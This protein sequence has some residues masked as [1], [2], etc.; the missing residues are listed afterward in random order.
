MDDTPPPA[1][2]K[3]YKRPVVVLNTAP[4][5]SL[6]NSSR[7]ETLNASKSVQGRSLRPLPSVPGGETT[8]S[9]SGTVFPPRLHKKSQSAV[10]PS[11]E[12]PWKPPSLDRGPPSSNRWDPAV[13]N[14]SPPQFRHREA[15][16][17]PPPSSRHRYPGP[18]PSSAGNQ[19]PQAPMVDP[20]SFYNPAVSGHLSR[21]S[22]RMQTPTRSTSNNYP[23]NIRP[24]QP[25]NTN[26]GHVR[27]AS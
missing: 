7:T 24:N 8:S 11:I 19:T 17:A 12:R 14:P 15:E 4:A 10:I 6:D 26:P 3:E 22:P 16:F 2:S 25:S 13:I 1:Y 20:N 9:K 21:P 27:W 23:L 18:P 5:V